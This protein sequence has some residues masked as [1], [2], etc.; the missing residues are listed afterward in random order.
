M[1]QEA[2]RKQ[3][4]L[5]LKGYAIL[6]IYIEI[7]SIYFQVRNSFHVN[8]QFD[9]FILPEFDGTLMVHHNDGTNL[10]HSASLDFPL[11]GWFQSLSSL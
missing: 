10:S 8:I 6:I 5:A 9:V 7:F 11:F 1:T 2:D 3:V 4:M